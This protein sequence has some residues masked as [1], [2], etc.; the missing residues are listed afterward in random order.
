PHH[1]RHPEDRPPDQ[2]PL[3]VT[4]PPPDSSARPDQDQDQ[5]KRHALIIAAVAQPCKPRLGPAA[6]KEPAS[7]RHDS[8]SSSGQAQARQPLKMTTE[9]SAPHASSAAAQPDR[10]H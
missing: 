9:E 1:E 4:D 3:G 5:D 7:A 6:P 10:H 8:P 2:T